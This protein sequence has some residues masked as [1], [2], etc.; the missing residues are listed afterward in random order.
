MNTAARAINESKLEH[1][2]LLAGLFSRQHFMVMVLALAV[3]VSGFAVIYT[4]DY[5]RRLY[6]KSQNLSAQANQM[7]TQWGKLLLEQSA[8]SMQA[9]VEHIASTQ[10]NMVVPAA[11]SIVMVAE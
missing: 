9:R 6:I 1:H 11:K 2:R 7:Q 4:K 8:W 3:F 5:Q 10:L